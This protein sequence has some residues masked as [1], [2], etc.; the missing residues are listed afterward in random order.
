MGIDD[1]AQP[2]LKEGQLLSYMRKVRGFHI[3]VLLTDQGV[4]T[5]ARDYLQL[6]SS[7]QGA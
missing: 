7:H 4:A 2:T 5:V 1:P 6:K 3:Y